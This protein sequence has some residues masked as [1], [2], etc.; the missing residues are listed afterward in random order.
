MK[1][2]EHHPVC[3]NCS[4][5]TQRCSFSDQL[6]SLP[7]PSISNSASTSPLPWSRTLAR[8]GAG[9]GT[10]SPA[11]S[12]TV[13][14]SPGSAGDAPTISS[15]PPSISPVATPLFDTSTSS[16]PSEDGLRF[17]LSHLALLHHLEK[18]RFS[19]FVASEEDITAL[20]DMMFRTGTAAPY[21]MDE[22]LAFSALHLSTTADD[23]AVKAR[24]RQQA[25]EL[26]TRA[27][28]QFNIT[29][30]EIRDENCVAMFIFSSMLG[31][32]MLFETGAAFD[33]DLTDFLDSF[34]KYLTLHRGVRT[35]VRNNWDAI[36]DTELRIV[37]SPV[38]HFDRSQRPAVD[39]QAQKECDRLLDFVSSLPGDSVLTEACREAVQGLSWVLERHAVLEI[40]YRPHSVSAWPVMLS[41]EYVDLLK[42]RRPEALVILAHWAVLLYQD[43]H[44]WVFGDTGRI[45]VLAITKHL[46]SYWDE[47]LAWPKEVLRDDN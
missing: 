28:T 3:V 8:Q 47:W 24:Y 5:A 15:F 19:S 39:T 22:L 20:F 40:M 23:A 11:D 9:P 16:L 35:V 21:L 34:V 44:F 29:P 6:P 38:E 36:R 43:R 25:T 10:Q 26:Q 18:G 27:L 33:G 17:S 2:D 13:T 12:E 7:T 14:P 42:Q 41:A 4:T 30:P 37:I 1:C 32:H 45:L 31:L 46:G